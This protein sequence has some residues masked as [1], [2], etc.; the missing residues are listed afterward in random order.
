MRKAA[1]RWDGTE[2]LRKHQLSPLQIGSEPDHRLA[3]V[4]TI[5]A[6]DEPNLVKALE[7]L[8]VCA[9]PVEAVEIIVGLNL[10]EDSTT[11]LQLRHAKFLGAARRF[12]AE[13][14][15]AGYR[16]HILDYPALPTRHAT[17]ARGLPNVE[18]QILRRAYEQILG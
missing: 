4:V 6:H 9:R 16:I 14:S 17:R 3:L 18:L 7:S 1:R 13:R 11:A 2:Y 12:A 15:N 10:P 8:S 5:P